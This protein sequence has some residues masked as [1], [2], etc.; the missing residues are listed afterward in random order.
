MTKGQG[1]GKGWHGDSQAHAAAGQKGG[2]VS[3][4]NFRHNPARAAAAGKLGGKVSPGNFRNNPE[5]ARV[6][7]KK[8]GSKTHAAKVSNV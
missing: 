6:A 8:G 3:S 2:K 5:R 7:G 4:G 1:V